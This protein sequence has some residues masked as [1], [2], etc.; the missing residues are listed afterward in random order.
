[1]AELHRSEIGQHSRVLLL[2]FR[3]HFLKALFGYC[4]IDKL[5]STIPFA[6]VFIFMMIFLFISFQFLMLVL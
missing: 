4:V 1:M 5:N 6:P 2:R 3:F